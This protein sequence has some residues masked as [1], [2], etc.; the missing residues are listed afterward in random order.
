MIRN[1]YSSWTLEMIQ[2]LIQRY[3]DESNIDLA[4]RYGKTR[5][6]VKAMAVKVGARKHLTD[7]RIK[8]QE[9]TIL[10]LGERKIGTGIVSVRG[11]VTVHRS[12]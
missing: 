2:D 11:N 6:A 8:L 9:R 4:I 5:Q 7:E 10:C 12:V 1:T 3:P